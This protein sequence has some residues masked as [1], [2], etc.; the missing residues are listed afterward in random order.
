MEDDVD[1]SWR[2]TSDSVVEPV[3]RNGKMLEKGSAKNSTGGLGV[4]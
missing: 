1:A 3:V 2:K 4:R